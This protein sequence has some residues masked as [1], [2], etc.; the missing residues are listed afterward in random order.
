MRVRQTPEYKAAMKRLIEKRKKRREDKERLLKQ[1]TE[2]QIKIAGSEIP[3][4]P[5]STR[6]EEW[7]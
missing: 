3:L 6:E 7:R 1:P 5:E 4:L 2:V